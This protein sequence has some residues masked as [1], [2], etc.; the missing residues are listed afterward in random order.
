MGETASDNTN[1]ISDVNSGIRSQNIA[2]VIL[3][4]V[5]HRRLASVILDFCSSIA[6]RTGCC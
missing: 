6:T 2:A 3:E 4:L 5:T 1:E